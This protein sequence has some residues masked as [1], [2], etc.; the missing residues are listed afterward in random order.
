MLVL[1]AAV[2]LIVWRRFV[3]FQDG[4]G[5]GQYVP[6]SHFFDGLGLGVEGP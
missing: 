4:E 5:Q 2:D 1:V 6:H 3:V